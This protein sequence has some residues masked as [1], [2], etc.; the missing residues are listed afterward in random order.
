MALRHT[1]RLFLLA[2]LVW[3]IGVY[4]DLFLRDRTTDGWGLGTSWRMAIPMGVDG[5]S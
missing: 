2:A 1:I 3:Q 4:W 5:D